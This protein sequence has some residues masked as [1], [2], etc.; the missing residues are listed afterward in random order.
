MFLR[1]P[2]DIVLLDDVRGSLSK[3]RNTRPRES[4]LRDSLMAF[5]ISHRFFIRNDSLA[6]MNHRESYLFDI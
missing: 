2:L 4:V 1:R 6:A 5:G 3:I